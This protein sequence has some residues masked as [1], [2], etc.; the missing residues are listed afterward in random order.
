M[1]AQENAV[2]VDGGG[3]KR[4]YHYRPSRLCKCLT[5]EG[6][7]I[8]LCSRTDIKVVFRDGRSIRVTFT[9]P[10]PQFYGPFVG[11]SSVLEEGN[12]FLLYVA[13]LGHTE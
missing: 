7:C 9:E 12:I 5:E 1:C 4:G 11:D 2:C 6:S 8:V 3:H 10:V 13:T